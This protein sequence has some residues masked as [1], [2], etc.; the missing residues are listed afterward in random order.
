MRMLHMQAKQVSLM[1]CARMQA[2]K[3]V[4]LVDVPDEAFTDEYGALSRASF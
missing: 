4:I 1:C 3:D 2:G